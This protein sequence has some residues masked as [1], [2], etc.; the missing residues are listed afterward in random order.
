MS[1]LDIF[2][3]VR[4]FLLF[5]LCFILYVSLSLKQ[6]AVGLFRWKLC[7]ERESGMSTVGSWLVTSIVDLCLLTSLM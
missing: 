4:S 1:V 6:S 7:F 5:I 2:V 3:S